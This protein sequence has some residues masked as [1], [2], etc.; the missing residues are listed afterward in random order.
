MV[1][2]FYFVEEEEE[3]E[4]IRWITFVGKSSIFIVIAWKQHN[5]VEK[6]ENVIASSLIS[7]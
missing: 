1:A 2:C 4:T 3:E 5:Q 6:L 7:I